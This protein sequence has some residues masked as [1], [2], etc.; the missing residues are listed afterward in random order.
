MT[1]HEFQ[2]E[3]RWRRKKKKKDQNI[4]VPRSSRSLSMLSYKMEIKKREK[5]KNSPCAARS[6]TNRPTN[7]RGNMFSCLCSL[8]QQTT[9]LALQLPFALKLYYFS[10]E[11]R[12]YIREDAVLSRLDDYRSTELRSERIHRYEVDTEYK[13]R[14]RARVVSEER[15]RNRAPGF[16]RGLAPI[17]CALDTVQTRH[18]PRFL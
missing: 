3:R 15:R 12:A 5:G 11:K 8:C 1:L 13:L 16:L 6:I 7:R 4:K 10:G 9:Q 18:A 14:E 17:G 2:Y